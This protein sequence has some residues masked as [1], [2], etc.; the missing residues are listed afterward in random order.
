MI[1]HLASLLA[2]FPGSAN[3]TRCF[4][5]IL[6]LVAKC[7]M[8]QFDAPKK[9]KANDNV[10]DDDDDDV[11]ADLQVALD[12]LEG[13]LEDDDDASKDDRDWEFDIRIDLSEEQID[14][15]EETVKPVRRVL[16]K[17]N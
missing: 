8:K 9:K 12:E 15:L 4:T 1:D 2:A 11:V 16:T 6:N 3:R 10:V 14:E 13:E 5:H 7:I 17:V